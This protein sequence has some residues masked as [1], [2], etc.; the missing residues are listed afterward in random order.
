MVGLAAALGTGSRVVSLDLLLL[1]GHDLGFGP[2]S[3]VEMGCGQQGREQALDLPPT[4]S[5]LPETLLRGVT[6]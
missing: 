6:K 5:F 4:E 1:A 2:P 3:W